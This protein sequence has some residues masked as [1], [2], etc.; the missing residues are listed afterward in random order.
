MSYEAGISLILF[1]CKLALKW[2]FRIYTRR[3]QEPHINFFMV[4]IGRSEDTRARYRENDKSYTKS[5]CRESPQEYGSK[6]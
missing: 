4:K 3:F 6:K 5:L 2:Y 1:F